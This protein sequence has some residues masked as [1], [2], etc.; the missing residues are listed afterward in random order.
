MVQHEIERYETEAYKAYSP[1][2]HISGMLDKNLVHVQNEV[3]R[4]VAV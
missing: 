3:M 2:K 1:D 4:G